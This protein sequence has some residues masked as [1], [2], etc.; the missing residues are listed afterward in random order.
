MHDQV[1]G[2]FFFEEQTINMITYLDMLQLCAVPQ[3]EHFNSHTSFCYKC[4]AR[5]RLLRA[6]CAAYLFT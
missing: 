1:I 2:P 3:I 6:T 5:E 4:T